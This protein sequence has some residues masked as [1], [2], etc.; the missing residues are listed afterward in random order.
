[1]LNQYTQNLGSAP[2]P[3]PT[4]TRCGTCLSLQQPELRQGDHGESVQV[5]PSEFEAGL[6]SMRLEQEK[7]WKMLDETGALGLCP[8]SLKDN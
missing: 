3:H 4:S 7:Q 2:T 8:Y 1:M 6:S 5:L